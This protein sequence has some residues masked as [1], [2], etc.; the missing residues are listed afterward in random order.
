MRCSAI[1]KCIWKCKLHEGDVDSL[2]IK[3][4]FWVDT[5]KSW[6]QY[7]YYKEDR[8][9]NQII[10]YNSHIKVNKKV[11][12]W[13]DV[14]SKGL[15]YIHQLYEKQCL[16]SYEQVWQEFSLTKLRYNSLKVAIPRAWRDFFSQN[17]KIEYTP[18]PPHIYDCCI[19]PKQ[20]SIS[21]KVYRF[22]SDDKMLIHNKYI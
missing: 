16:K 21:Q 18:L 2:K 11:I 13:K 22:V 5:L 17:A 10:W 19:Q 20:K 8:I 1:G 7:N 14:C 6:C 4:Q 12:M 3:N 15:M 9:E